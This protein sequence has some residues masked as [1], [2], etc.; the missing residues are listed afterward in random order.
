MLNAHHINLSHCLLKSRE[1]YLLSQINWFT[2]DLILTWL[3]GCFTATVF[4]G[5]WG[6]NK[7]KWTDNASGQLQWQNQRETERF[8][9]WD[10]QTFLTEFCHLVGHHSHVSDHSFKLPPGRAGRSGLVLEQLQVTAC[11]AVPAPLDEQVRLNASS[12]NGA[13][14]EWTHGSSSLPLLQGQ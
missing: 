10:L 11:A 9:V 7:H 4:R 6:S 5:S 8:N 14:E 1:Y 2:H 13:G 3:I 12:W